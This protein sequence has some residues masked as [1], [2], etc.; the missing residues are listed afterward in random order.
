[1]HSGTNFDNGFQSIVNL[2]PNRFTLN[3]Y[4]QS[5]YLIQNAKSMIYIFAIEEEAN[6]YTIINITTS[7]QL[8]IVKGSLSLIFS[9]HTKKN[10]AVNVKIEK[11]INFAVNK[12]QLI[13]KQITS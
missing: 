5:V 2:G 7:F 6:I 3:H 1:M 9:S 8:I 11:W 13:G 12:V 4:F 10:S